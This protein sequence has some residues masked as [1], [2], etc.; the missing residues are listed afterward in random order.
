LQIWPD[1]NVR[2]TFEG[3]FFK[4]QQ[5]CKVEKESSLPITTMHWNEVK[6]D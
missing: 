5:L 2:L 3:I 4:R 1:I 6:Q